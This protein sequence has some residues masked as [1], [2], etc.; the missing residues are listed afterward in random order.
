[1]NHSDEQNGPFRDAKRAI[2][3]NGEIFSAILFEL[4]TVR[5]AIGFLKRQKIPTQFFGNNS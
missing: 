4:F 3:K 2:L 1:M 5:R